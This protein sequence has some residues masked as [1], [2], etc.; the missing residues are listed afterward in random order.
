MHLPDEPEPSPQINIVPMIDVIF[1][2]LIFFILS[3]LYL[4]Q[5]EGLPI[6]LPEAST[7]ESQLAQHTI[8]LTL[9]VEGVLQVGNEVAT[10]A[11]LPTRIQAR[12][13]GDRP[14]LVVI[15][16]DERVS[17]GEVVAV[18]DRLR[19]LQGIQLGIATGSEVEVYP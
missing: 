7:S 10:L 5:S 16:A 18:M 17:H 1:V 12:R 19:T 9:T 2:I 8:F 13:V 15:R 14:I 6:N 3:S 4:T 11:E